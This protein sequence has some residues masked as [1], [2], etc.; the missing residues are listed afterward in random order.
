VLQIE[1]H[2]LLLQ[3]SYRRGMAGLFVGLPAWLTRNDVAPHTSLEAK[4]LDDLFAE[5]GW[6]FLSGFFG[7]LLIHFYS[8]VSAPI[9]SAGRCKMQMQNLDHLA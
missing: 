5:F 1:Q 8:L 3:N 9:L 7:P 6:Q 2:S 4:R